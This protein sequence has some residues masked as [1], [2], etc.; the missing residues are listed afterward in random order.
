MKQVDVIRHTD[1]VFS[2]DIMAIGMMRKLAPSDA[3]KSRCLT[4]FL[5]LV[6]SFSSRKPDGPEVLPSWAR[7]FNRHPN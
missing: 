4:P 2:N 5:F 6:R 3:I 1:K 7:D